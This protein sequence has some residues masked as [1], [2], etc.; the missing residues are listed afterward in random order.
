MKKKLK[1]VSYAKW[2]YVFILPFFCAILF[3]P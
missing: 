2:G 3:S 1:S